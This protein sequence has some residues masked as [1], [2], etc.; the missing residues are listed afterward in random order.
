MGPPICSHRHAVSACTGEIT[1]YQADAVVFAVGVGAM[2]ARVED[3]KS[4][5]R[6]A[7]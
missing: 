7:S 5:S 6:V 3:G 1:S 2:Q 4:G